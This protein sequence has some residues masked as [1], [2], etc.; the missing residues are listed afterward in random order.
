MDLHAENVT[1]KTA[2]LILR[3]V[4][5]SDEGPIVSAISDIA[6]AGW[7]ATVPHPY[8]AADFRSFV[9]EIAVP[10]ETF[11]I[12]DAA[13]VAGVV[14]IEGGELGYWLVPH[15]QGM[16]YATEAARAALQWYFSRTA[17]SMLSGYFIGNDRSARVL[18]KLGFTQI[19]LGVRHCA[20][21]DQDRPHADMVLTPG[22]FGRSKAGGPPR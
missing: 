8:T 19:G 14:G 11:V 4:A 7:L 10:G 12:E 21:L 13:G 5:L 18:A 3:P 15:A 22:A 2:R 17:E 1:L 20:A 9:T 16:G 6:V